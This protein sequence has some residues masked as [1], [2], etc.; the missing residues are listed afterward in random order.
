MDDNK[1]AEDQLLLQPEIEKIAPHWEGKPWKP[2]KPYTVEEMDQR[3]E[4]AMEDIKN[5]K[6]YTLE[7]V[8]QAVNELYRKHGNELSA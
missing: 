6:R 8:Q 5:G 1:V 4:E 3:I 7:E 2:G